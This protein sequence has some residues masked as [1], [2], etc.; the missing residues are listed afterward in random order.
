MREQEGDE[1]NNM[2]ASNAKAGEGS[3]SD[4]RNSKVRHNLRSLSIDGE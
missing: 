3:G 1:K 2:T 4:V